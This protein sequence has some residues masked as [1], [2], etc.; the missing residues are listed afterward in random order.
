[1]ITFMGELNKSQQRRLRGDNGRGKTGE[2]G[3]PGDQN[4][5]KCQ[6]EWPSWEEELEDDCREPPSSLLASD[7][8]PDSGCLFSS[9]HLTKPCLAVSLG[10]QNQGHTDYP[11]TRPLEF[12]LLP[13][14]PTSLP[15]PGASLIFC[16]FVP[17]GSCRCTRVSRPGSLQKQILC[18]NVFCNFYAWS[19]TRNILG[20]FDKWKKMPDGGGGMVEKEVTRLVG[21]LIW[22]TYSTYLNI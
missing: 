21:L 11:E 8:T 10:L 5:G 16:H 18:L 17:K 14:S 15:Q 2:R 1:M 3:Y 12:W 20:I 19:I 13:A 7:A 6:G 9:V 22:S 4:G